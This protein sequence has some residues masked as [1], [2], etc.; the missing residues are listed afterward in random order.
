M[1]GEREQDDTFI[2]EAIVVESMCLHCGENGTTRILPTAIPYFRSVVV[3]AFSCPHCNARYNEIQS[4]GE[5]QERGVRYT[6]RVS[7]AGDLNRQ[8]VR[9]G[10]AVVG[11]PELQ[12]EIP[13]APTGGTLT[14]VEGTLT[15]AAENLSLLQA[16]RRVGLRPPF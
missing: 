9:S 8:I 4:S 5:I 14:T 15:L 3:M 7:S 2:E 12:F 11:I 16:D 13:P 1:S 10:S 6:L